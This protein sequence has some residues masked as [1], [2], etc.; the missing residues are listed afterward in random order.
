MEKALSADRSNG[1]PAERRTDLPWTPSTV[2]RRYRAFAMPWLYAGSALWHWRHLAQLWRAHRES[3]LG[4]LI[5]ARPEIWSLL[6]V[7][8]IAAPWRGAA[9]FRRIIDHC[10]LAEQLGR[11]LDIRPTEAASLILMEEIGSAVV[12]RLECARW[13][14]REG[15]LT[16]SIVDGHSRIFSLTFTLASVSPGMRTAYVGGI[17]GGHG[18]DALDRNRSFTKAAE[19]ARPQ[20]L[21][22]ELFRSVCAS[23]DV[24][25]IL[26]VSDRIRNGRTTFAHGH[27]EYADPVT[28]DYDAMW[29]ARGGRLRDDGFFDV[30]LTQPAREDAHYPSKKRQARRKK[31]SLINRLQERLVARLADPT[32]ITI[33]QVEPA[34]MP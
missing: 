34:L 13:L 12:L 24:A 9:R 25:E 30:P 19:G 32:R 3:L 14:F 2:I 21:L 6:R 20:D 11:P 26:C 27:L 5:I 7:R 29:T 33:E 10:N 23:F 16:L 28:F 17:Q 4:S 15:L 1:P 22:F 8:F 31:L 18:G